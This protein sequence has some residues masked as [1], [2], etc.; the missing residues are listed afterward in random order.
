MLPGSY[1]PVKELPLSPS[2]KINRKALQALDGAGTGG[3]EEQFNP[4]A[5]PTEEILAGIWSKVLRVGQVGSQ[6]NF[7]QLGGH[8]LLSTQVMSRIRDIFHVDLPLKT[9]FETRDLAAL[10]ALIDAAR[11]NGSGSSAHP[12]VHVPRTDDIP[13]SFAQQ[14][15][16][17]LDQ[18]EPGNSNYNLPAAIHL[19]GQL[20]SACFI[21]C[22]NDLIQR[23]ESLR[24]ASP[25]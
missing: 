9:L 12:L 11:H 13:L 21:R 1:L 24:T 10:A 8:S 17:F 3:I 20:D 23:H 7:C 6:D 19:E 15:L 16:W 14:R 18:L 22:I 25:P 5:T 2:G 4:P